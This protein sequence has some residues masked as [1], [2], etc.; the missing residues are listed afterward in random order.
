VRRRANEKTTPWFNADCRAARHRARAAERR[1]K[2]TSSDA[3]YRVWS[4]EL[5]KMKELYE[6]KNSTFCLSEIATSHGN[7]QRLW[8][9]LQSVQARV[10]LRVTTPVLTQQ[11]ILPH[12]KGQS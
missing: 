9:T 10:S 4:A 11:M 6:E 3:D 2:R 8:Q 5:S 7:T 12:F 1:F